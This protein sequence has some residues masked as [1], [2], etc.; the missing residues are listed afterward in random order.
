MTYIPLGVESFYLNFNNLHPNQK[1]T[2]AK[3]NPEASKLYC[4]IHYH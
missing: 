2:D 1:P 4:T 3:R